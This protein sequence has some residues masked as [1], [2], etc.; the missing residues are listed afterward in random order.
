MSGSLLKGGTM[1]NHS[2]TIALGRHHFDQRSLLRH[3]NGGGGR[4]GLGGNRDGLSMI[5]HRS[6]NHPVPAFL[7][8]EL[9]NLVGRSTHLEGSC[10]LQIL[11]LEIYSGP[12]H[13]A[14]RARME[15]GRHMNRITNHLTGMLDLLPSWD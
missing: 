14:E 5:A 7:L 12:C 9:G 15:H 10:S 2:G 3:H 4:K 11:S 8:T 6:R 13:S 1:Q